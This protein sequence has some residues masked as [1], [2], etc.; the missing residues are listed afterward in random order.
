MGFEYH[1]GLDDQDMDLGNCT[2]MLQD[3]K[4]EMPQIMIQLSTLKPRQPSSAL[5]L[6][7][8]FT[9]RV[10]LLSPPDPPNTHSGFYEL[11]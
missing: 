5:W 8:S 10:Y 3:S 4:V 7:K 2:C 6:T 9:W 11:W 1:G